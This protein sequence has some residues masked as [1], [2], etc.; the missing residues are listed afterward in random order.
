MR[1][2]NLLE[3]PADL[4]KNP[5]ILQ[6]VLASWSQRHEREPEKLGPTRTE[7]LEHLRSAA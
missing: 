4:I 1:M 7:M 6:R 3:S 5:Q 2:F